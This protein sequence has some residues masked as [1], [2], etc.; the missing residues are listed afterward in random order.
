MKRGQ[1]IQARGSLDDGTLEHLVADLYLFP[2]WWDGLA[3]A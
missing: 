2:I 1:F 3:R